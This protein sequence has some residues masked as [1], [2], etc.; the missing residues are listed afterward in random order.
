[1]KRAIIIEDHPI[2]LEGLTG[3]LETLNWEV[4]P[5]SSFVEFAEKSSGKHFDLALVDLHLPNGKDG[6]DVCSELKSHKTHPKI[7]IISYFDQDHLVDKAQRLHVEGYLY[8]SAD[9]IEIEEA[10]STVMS[11][12]N[13]YSTNLK[14]RLA[15]KEAFAQ[16]NGIKLDVLEKHGIT[17]R[18]LDIILA[19]VESDKTSD[20]HI[21]KSME[22]SAHTVRQHRKSLHQKLQI[23]EATGLVKFYYEHLHEP[24]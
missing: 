18:E 19:I 2:Y 7:I 1:M 8:K 9:K 11:G 17:K 3:I 23:S 16:R 6:F 13:Y 15:S 10:I 12:H 4:T 22:M 20:K 21:A 24:E 14:K 5:C